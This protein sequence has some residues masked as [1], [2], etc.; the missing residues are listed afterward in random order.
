MDFVNHTGPLL[1]SQQYTLQCV[2]HD[3]APVQNL[4]VTFYK[5]QKPLGSL[6]STQT[7]NYKLPTTEIFTLDIIPRK[8]D[9]R[10]QYWCEAKLELE[11]AGEQLPLAV[12]SQKVTATVL[13]E[14]NLRY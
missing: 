9:D 6:Q 5:G 7:R 13:C 12:S 3:V 4:M 14:L 1:A 8:E 10:A 11:A 2:V